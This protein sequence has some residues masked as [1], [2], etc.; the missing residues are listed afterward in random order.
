MASVNLIVI[1]LGHFVFDGYLFIYLDHLLSGDTVSMTAL[2][3][4]WC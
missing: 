3:L 1:S 4:K 2:I